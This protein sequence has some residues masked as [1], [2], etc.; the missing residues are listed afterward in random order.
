MP[1]SAFRSSLALIRAAVAFAFM[2]SAASSESQST[3]EQLHSFGL[4]A[5]SGAYPTAAPIE[6]L[7]GGL[8]GS[9][10]LGGIANMGSLYRVK[11]DGSDFRY[12]LS[13]RGADGRS[14]T[15]PLVQDVS[16]RLFGTAEGGGVADQGV[17][18]RVLPDGTGFK[19]L[20][21]FDGGGSEGRRPYGG[22]LLASDGFLYGATYEGGLYGGGTIFKLGTDGE[23]FIVICH[24]GG[25]DTDGRHPRGALIEG[26]DGMLY[27]TTEAGG[28]EGN[29][30]VFAL[31]KYGFGYQVV[32]SFAMSDGQGA[33]GGIIE[34]QDGRLY[35]TL[36][37]GGPQGG[38]VA[39]ALNTDGTE[40]TIIRA[41][42]QSEGYGFSARLTQSSNGALLAVAS[43]GAANNVGGVLRFMSDGS[44]FTTLR[45]FVAQADNLYNG[46]TPVAIASDGRLY[47][48]T[49]VGGR[50]AV[51]GLGRMSA[52]G[53]EYSV[54]KSFSRSGTAA[55]YPRGELIRGTN[56]A[57]Y[58]ITERGGNWDHGTVFRVGSDGAGYSIIHSFGGSPGDPADPRAGVIEGRDGFLYGTTRLG[59]AGD[60]GAIFRLP[61]DGSNCQVLHSFRGT[62]GSP[63]DGAEPYARLIEGADGMLYGVASQGGTADQGAVFRL[64]KDGSGYSVLRSFLGGNA[65]GATPASALLEAHDG[66]LYGVTYGGGPQGA[67]SVFRIHTDGSNYQ[68]LHVFSSTAQSPANP[69]GALIQAS[70]GRLYGTSYSGGAG[71]GTVF[72]LASDGTDL[73]VVVSLPANPSG[74]VNPIGSLIEA[75]DAR[76]WGTSYQGGGAIDSGT[77]FSVRKD[78]SDYQTHHALAG[79]TDEG[80]GPSGGLLGFAD[81][82]FY[83]VTTLGGRADSGSLF[84]ICSPSAVR[85]ANL[86]LNTPGTSTITGNA[87]SGWICHLELTESLSASPSWSLVGI[88][89]A[90]QA[91][92]AVFLDTAGGG[93]AMRFYRLRGTP[94][95]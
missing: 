46:I 47:F 79:A 53:T 21:D 12:I 66:V 1:S 42:S 75:G 93:H 77:V 29:G 90:D 34:G 80:S 35:G 2:V 10:A 76:L 25:S 62:Q 28:V 39:Y 48:T 60:H 19:V 30:T 84:R 24:F 18:Y 20:K 52:D 45:A 50:D 16:G 31:S 41:F 33:Y 26:T 89:Q 15:A 71:G 91:G 88:Q 49:P 7:D 85:I 68:V 44:E 64:G 87:P 27:G 37:T 11:K 13:F 70:D 3:F 92:K 82:V 51:G 95:L 8:Y 72:S 81:G 94:A 58:G 65:D 6:G 74:G 61:R 55:T 67:G 63:A 4:S 36:Y 5:D 57:L 59:G 17:V 73:Q 43:Y 14:P 69:W 86:S 23:D 83:G 9:T 54:L 22:F 56:G 78:G 40:F 32:R 38:G